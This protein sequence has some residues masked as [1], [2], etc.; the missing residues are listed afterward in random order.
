[1]SKHRLK[2]ACRSVCA[3]SIRS[4]L[5]P[6]QDYLTSLGFFHPRRRRCV[7]AVEHFGRWIGRRHISRSC[8][9]EFIDQ[10]L[11]NCPCLGVS[12]DR[13]LNC[14]A[15]NHLLAMLGPSQEQS[16]Y[17]PG[18]LG[19]LLRSYAEHLADTRGPAPNTSVATWHI[20]RTCSA[21]SASDERLSSGT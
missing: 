6:Y 2:I 5:E 17:P 12:R 10:G 4:L 15:L 16:V 19:R 20:H 21:V 3:R 8:V 1:M 9:Q 13:K 11:P 7:R 14:A 18:H